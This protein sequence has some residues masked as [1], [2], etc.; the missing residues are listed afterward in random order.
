[1]IPKTIQNIGFNHGN[2]VF[3][4]GVRSGSGR[5]GERSRKLPDLI[6]QKTVYNE[7][8]I[9]NSVSEIL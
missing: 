2:F 1:M 3:Q 4:D 8:L 7:L 6:N 5:V 9:R